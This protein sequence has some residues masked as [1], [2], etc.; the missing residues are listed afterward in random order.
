MVSIVDFKKTAIYS[1]LVLILSIVLYLLFDHISHKVSDPIK[2]SLISEL[3]ISDEGKSISF[4]KFSPIKSSE[5]I[6][7]SKTIISI[8][9]LLV[10]LTTIIISHI[11]NQ[12]DNYNSLHDDFWFRSMYLKPLTESLE[13]F[14]IRW[15]IDEN[16]ISIIN[17]QSPTAVQTKT[18]EK[19]V[20][21]LSN[22]RDKAEFIK[23]ID[24]NSSTL[25]NDLF[26]QFEEDVHNNKVSAFTILHQGFLNCMYD[27]HKDIRKN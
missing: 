20:A 7:D 1:L 27:I 3:S 26:D 5:T 6:F 11:K 12:K 24:D 9:A 23:K 16:I 10:S 13:E 14:I 21:E 4:Q 8:L 19:F 17:N 25:I 22:L 18:L 15:K 2:P